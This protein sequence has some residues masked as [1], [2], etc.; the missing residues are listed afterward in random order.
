MATAGPAATDGAWEH[1]LGQI[2]SDGSVPKDTALDAFSL[3]IGPLPGVAAS[4]GPAGVIADGSGAIRWAVRY[5]DQLSAEQQAAIRAYAGLGSATAPTS[6]TSAT[7]GLSRALHVTARRPRGIVLPPDSPGAQIARGMVDDM[8]AFYDGKIGH[9][10]ATST[11]WRA[12]PASGIP[13]NIRLVAT[14][15]TAGAEAETWV[16]DDLDG[17]TGPM[18]RCQIDLSPTFLSD[19][20]DAQVVAVAHEV[21]H[22]FQGALAKA[23]ANGYYNEP[24]WKIEG[25][26]QWAALEASA[27][28][29]GV[30]LDYGNFLREYLTSPQTSLFS[31]AYNAAGFYDQVVDAGVDVW[32]LFSTFYRTTASNLAAYN[33]IA[34]PGGDTF[35]DAWGP[36]YSRQ[37]QRS[38]AWDVTGPAVPSPAAA[39]PPIKSIDGV[40][41]GS[42]QQVTAAAFTVGVYGIRS[43]ADITHLEFQG[44]ARVGDEA[45][46]D[47]VGLS[48]IDLCTKADQQCAC[49][50][51]GSP[52][53]SA[54]TGMLTLGITGGPD[55]SK[56]TISGLALADF[57]TAHSTTTTAVP[58][59]SGQ[60]WCAWVIDVNTRHGTMVNNQYIQSALRD[61]TKETAIAQE[62]TQHRS[63]ALSITPPELL[64]AQTEEL[65]YF[66]A[67][68]QD[69]S[70]APPSDF[71]AS[72]QVLIDYQKSVCGIS[73]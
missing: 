12:N 24:P 4:P 33:V 70:T 47:S 37:S 46:F 41:N 64:A 35:L 45:S 13:T 69:P 54:V 71:L 29:R 8:I 53:P 1:V 62:A 50:D 20:A 40:T 10:L 43:Q 59:T 73:F 60:A 5:Y 2:S 58:D 36:G 72:Q 31:R 55:G 52:T 44:H 57:C 28:T 26:A 6:T 7:A 15:T 9:L 16:F 14:P 61:I 3:A 25:G 42:S 63:Y 38:A 66:A 68:L 49:P 67:F 18:G 34:Q 27:A 48:S 32:T 51:A 65:D 39:P 19:T 30:S 56:A 11:E 22:C 23:V 17:F 21:F